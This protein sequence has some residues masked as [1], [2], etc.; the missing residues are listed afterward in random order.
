M[1]NFKWFYL[2]LFLLLVTFYGGW[3]FIEN[4]LSVDVPSEVEKYCSKK[5]G[6]T[7]SWNSYISEENTESSRVSLVSDK[8]SIK[9]K[10]VR[11]YDLNGN[12]HYKDNYLGY[13]YEDKIYE[14]LRET[15]P[16]KYNFTLSI[17]N[18][19][20]A[21][22]EDS[23]IDVA[24]FCRN[25]DTVLSLTFL[26]EMSENEISEVVSSLRGVARVSALIYANNE[27]INQFA[28]GKDFNL[29]R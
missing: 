17:K 19:E 13:K 6:E 22:I 8:D 2:I 29:I 14:L 26:S 25:S 9:F 5:Y 24:E 10:V 1:R 21:D 23:S 20:F 7:F 18:S 4:T 28:T 12:I 27:E 16:E 15:I 3:Y 11:Y